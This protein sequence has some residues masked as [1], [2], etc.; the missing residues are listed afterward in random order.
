MS[1]KIMNFDVIYIYIYIAL[2]TILLITKMI[3]RKI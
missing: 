3:I 2:I 1:I